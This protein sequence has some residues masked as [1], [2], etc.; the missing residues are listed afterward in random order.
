VGRGRGVPLHPRSQV[1][2][3][4]KSRDNDEIDCELFA[5]FRAA[6]RSLFRGKRA[7]RVSVIGRC[8]CARAQKGLA[9]GV[10]KSPAILAA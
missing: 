2:N 8:N 3:H 10:E 6:A 7:F 1:F 5:N 9:L 4:G